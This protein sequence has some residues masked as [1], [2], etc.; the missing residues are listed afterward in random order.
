VVTRFIHVNV[1]CSD[2]DR[3]VA[4][5]TE[6]LGARIHQDLRSL[7]SDLRPCMGQEE[8]DAPNYKAVL[9]YFN[10]KERGGPY[11]DLVEW[12][13]DE[14]ADAERSGRPPL[15]AQDYGLV[16]IALEVPDIDAARAHVESTGTEIIGPTQDEPVG[17]WRLKLF[18]CKDP[19][20][21]LIE[22]VEFPEGQTRK[23]REAAQT[24]A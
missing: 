19:D 10:D 13:Y 4:W 3:S 15:E 12:H 1:V 22:L 2:L 5:Y 16:R 7:G 24:A 18:L 17:P 21:T 23:P 11:I 8:E 14:D 20:G 6:V 9:L